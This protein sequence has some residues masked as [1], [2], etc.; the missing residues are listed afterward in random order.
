MFLKENSNESIK[1]QEC[2]DR[3]NRKDVAKPQNDASP[4]DARKPALNML[5]ID[6]K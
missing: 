6:E 2:A 5:V 3:R 1:S 4:T